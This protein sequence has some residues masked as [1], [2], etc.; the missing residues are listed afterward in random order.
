MSYEEIHDELSSK[1]WFSED[2]VYV[3]FDGQYGSTGKGLLSSTLAAAMAHRIEL[4][5][6]SAGP[7]SGHTFYH[8]GKKIVSQQLPSSTLKLAALGVRHVCYLNAGALIRAEILLRELDLLHEL[9]K[10]K[11]LVTVLVHPH[12]AVI[13]DDAIGDQASHIASTGKGVGPALQAKISRRAENVCASLQDSK[14][15]IPGAYLTRHPHP[16]RK[17]ALLEIAQGWSLGINSGF[18]P[19]VTARECSVSQGLSDLGV[20]PSACRKSIVALRA[21]PIRVGNTADGWSGP[22]YA[23]QKETTWDEIGVE[24]E[25]TTVTKRVRRVFTWSWLQFTDMLEANEPDALFLNFCNYLKSDEEVM[26]F[27]YQCAEKYA[28][29]LG[30]RPDFM[31]LGFGPHDEDV[32]LVRT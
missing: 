24:P 16:S 27:A 25:I 3:V 21:F 1:G 29:V 18:Y 20:A 31:L 23:D 5:T 28:R 15:A 19:Y 7:N 6:T 2:G 8:K 13:H 26:L 9:S 10:W 12:A 14:D 4:V 22:C 30:K 17:R 32:R 11:D